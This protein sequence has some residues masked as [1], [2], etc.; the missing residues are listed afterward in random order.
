MLLLHPAVLAHFTWVLLPWGLGPGDEVIMADTNWIATAA[1]IVHLGAKP[2]FIDILLESWC[3]N[4]SL[5]EEAITPRTKAIIAVHIYGNLCEMNQLLAIGDKYNIPVI[6]D[7]A[8]AIG[9][10]LPQ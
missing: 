10:C 8:E 6:E 3:I 7:S 1:P 2:V 4:P 5:I 9:S